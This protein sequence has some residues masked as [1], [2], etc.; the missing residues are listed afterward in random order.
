MR[1]TDSVLCRVDA[2]T[3]QPVAEMEP[4]PA[5][6]TLQALIDALIAIDL[7][8]ERERDELNKSRLAPVSWHRMVRTLREQHRQ[9]REPYVQQLFARQERFEARNRSPDQS[10]STWSP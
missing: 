4:E 1:V 7:A 2:R 9:R 3:Q 5:R 6:L 8:F 10:T